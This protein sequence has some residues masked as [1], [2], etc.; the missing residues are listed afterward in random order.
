MEIPIDDFRLPV[1]R[2]WDSNWFLLTSGDFQSGRFNSMTVSWGSFGN[3][4]NLPIAMVVVR[5]SRYTFAF[6]NQY[7]D[8]TLCSFPAQYGKALGLM[9]SMSGR[10]G[11]KISQSGLTPRA[12]VRVSAPVYAEA[13]LTIECRKL[14]W[15]DYN[16][17]NFLDE[18]IFKQY[19]EKDYHRMFLGE[20]LFVEGNPDKFA[21]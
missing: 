10:D 6:I 8:F 17:E 7:S 11:D 13:D 2:I 19:P 9:G 21:D 15:Q 1:N 14:Y 3:M 16:P 4:W 5:P 12:A 18:S 20:I